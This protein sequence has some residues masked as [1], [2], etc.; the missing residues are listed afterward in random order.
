VAKGTLTTVGGYI[1]A[2]KTP[3]MVRMAKSVADVDVERERAFCGFKVF[4]LFAGRVVYLTEEPRRSFERGLRGADIRGELPF[5]V[6]FWDE[7]FGIKWPDI[8]EQAWRQADGGIVFVDTAFR[9]ASPSLTGGSAENDSATMQRVY[10]PLIQACARET[11]VVVSAHTVKG[12]DRWD[13]GE[14]DISAIRG[15]GA[16]AAQSSVI[17]LYKKAYPAVSDNVRFLRVGRTRLQAD[18]PEDRYVT[19]TSEGMTTMGW[20]E[21]ELLKDQ[22]VNDRALSLVERLSP[23]SYPDLRAAW[24]GRP[25]DL[26]RAVKRLVDDGRVERDGGGKKGDPY[27]FRFRFPSDSFRETNPGNESAPWRESIPV[28]NLRYRETKTNLGTNPGPPGNE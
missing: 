15:S 24:S 10:G 6:V 13:D 27:V 2:G 22:S 1:G 25:E 14:A 8:V 5:D 16:V 4:P 11:S 23:V 19:L 26:G 17:V 18:L 20:V 28:G 12:F 7:S 9:W 3:L 21:R